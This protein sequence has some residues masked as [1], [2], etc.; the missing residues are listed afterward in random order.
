[1]SS[2]LRK[3][4]VDRWSCPYCQPLGML[5][6][7]Q[8]MCPGLVAAGVAQ[9]DEVLGAS[10]RDPAS[11]TSDSVGRPGNPTVGAVQSLHYLVCQTQ[12]TMEILQSGCA[13]RYVGS[14]GIWTLLTSALGFAEADCTIRIPGKAHPW[15]HVHSHRHSANQASS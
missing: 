4:P 2:H 15:L 1:M 10:F 13:S 5:V 8:A 7:L 14:M 11:C 3:L 9:L 12:R 6:S